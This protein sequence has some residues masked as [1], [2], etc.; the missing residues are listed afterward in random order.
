MVS[1]DF[2]SIAVLVAVY[3]TKGVEVVG[4]AMALVASIPLFTMLP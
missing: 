3:A 1:I 2:I 4:D